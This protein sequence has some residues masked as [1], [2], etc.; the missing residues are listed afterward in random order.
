MKIEVSSAC[1]AGLVREENQDAILCCREGEFG[2]FLVADGMG[3]HTDGGRAS[4]AIAEGMQAWLDRKREFSG[5][6][7]ELLREARTRLEEIHG[8]IWE[9][10]NRGQ[11]CGSTCTMLLVQG[12][13]YGV[14]NVGDSRVYRSRGLRCRAITRDDV[15]ENQRA[16]MEKYSP[17]EVRA[18]PC[19]GKLLHAVGSEKQLSC[20]IETERLVRGDVFALCSDGVYKMCSPG[21]LRRRIASCRRKGLESVRKEI[22][23]EVY[24][25]GAADNASLILVRC[26]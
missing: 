3:G 18:H 25:N 15:W 5:G 23:A 13:R 4:R 9:R 10:W 16:V 8:E 7:A 21:S 14:L 19:Y 11:V 12:E 26:L 6:A 22:M 17:D 24:R 2:L 20:A 1:E